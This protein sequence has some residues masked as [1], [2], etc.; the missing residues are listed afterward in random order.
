MAVLFDIRVCPFHRSPS[1]TLFVSSLSSVRT[2]GLAHETVFLS[3]KR[4][5]PISPNPSD[6]QEK[7]LDTV[8][9]QYQF[10]R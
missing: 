10:T 3:H 8:L 7:L 2:I 5:V 9:L 4:I 6:L 1:F